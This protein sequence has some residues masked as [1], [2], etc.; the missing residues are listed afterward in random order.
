MRRTLSIVAYLRP[1]FWFM[2]NPATGL[3]KQQ[4]FMKPYA[5]IDVDYCQFSNWGYRK[6]TRVW[7]GASSDEETP[8]LQGRLCDGDQ[9]PNLTPN[10]KRHRVT[11][12]PQKG[13]PSISQN[14]KYRVPARLVAYLAGLSTV[15]ND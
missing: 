7:Y 2:E 12:C 8:T 4:R 6:R 1:K 5:F 3:L 15:P 13:E 14:T 11:L 9:C 10:K